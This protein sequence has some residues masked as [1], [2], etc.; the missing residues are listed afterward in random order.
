M[1]G[2]Q[3]RD[4]RA[5]VRALRSGKHTVVPSEPDGSDPG[6]G[7]DSRCLKAF[8]RKRSCSRRTKPWTADE[9]QSSLILECH[10]KPSLENIPCQ[11]EG[12]EKLIWVPE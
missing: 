11:K 4:G 12:A 7:T 10:Q 2:A 9:P 5:N 1:R 3:E 6:P 8:R